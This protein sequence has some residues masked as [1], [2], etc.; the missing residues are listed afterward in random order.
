MH[1]YYTDDRIFRLP[2][3]MVVSVYEMIRVVKVWLLKCY[4]DCIYSMICSNNDTCIHVQQ[5]ET[6]YIPSNPHTV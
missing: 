2:G 1:T 6:V 5:L 4:A 3:A